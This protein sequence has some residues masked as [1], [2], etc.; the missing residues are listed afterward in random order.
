LVAKNSGHRTEAILS[1]AQ[2]FAY[3]VSFLGTTGSKSP[4]FKFVRE[5][6]AKARTRGIPLCAGFGISTPQDVRQLV[7]AGCDG[8]VVGSAICRI[9]AKGGDGMPSELRGYCRALKEATKREGTGHG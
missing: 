9:I 3:L 6:V 2:G 7:D 5:A 1:R 4:D 8:V